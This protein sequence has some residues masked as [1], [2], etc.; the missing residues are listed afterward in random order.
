MCNFELVCTLMGVPSSKG[1]SVKG[2]YVS[3]AYYEG[4]IK[5]ISEYCERDVE[6]SIKLAIEIS[7]EKL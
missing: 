2:K 7:A 3:T 4:R 5:E 6:A 1:G